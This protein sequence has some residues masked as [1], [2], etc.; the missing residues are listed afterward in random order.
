[1]AG[2]KAEIWFNVA[3]K[4]PVISYG[5]ADIETMRMS[6]KL[7]V[8]RTVQVVATDRSGEIFL[9]VPANTEIVNNHTVIHCPRTNLQAISTRRHFNNLQE[10]LEDTRDGDWLKEGEYLTV[11]NVGAFR[12]MGGSFPDYHMETSGGVKLHDM[13]RRTTLAANTL[14]ARPAGTVGFLGGIAYITDP[15]ATGP[16]SD[17]FDLGV[18]G[19]KNADLPKN[20][21]NAIDKCKA[22]AD[23]PMGTEVEAGKYSARHWAEVSQDAASQI[24]YW[25]GVWVRGVRYHKNDRVFHEGST[26]QANNIH[27]SN[28]FHDDMNIGRWQI[29]A[30][31][32]E[33]GDNGRNVELRK[34]LTHVQWRYIGDENWLNLIPLA[35][36]NGRSFTVDQQG[37]LVDRGLFDDEPVG[38]AYLAT[39]NG[40]LYFRQGDAGGWSDGIPFGKGDA[41]TDGREVQLRVNASHV[42]WQYDGDA[43]W[44]NLV[45]LETIRG[46]QGVQG[47]PGVDGTDGVDGR[48]VELRQTMTHIQWR[49]VGAPTWADLMPLSAIT[50]PQGLPGSDGTDGREIE[51]RNASSYIQ[52]RYVGAVNWN[53]LVPLTAITGPAGDT[54]DMRSTGGMIQWKRTSSGTW[55]NL[56]DTAEAVAG[57][58]NVGNRYEVNGTQVVGAQRNAIAD[59]ASSADNKATVNA[60]LAALRA[61]GLIAT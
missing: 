26:Y 36:I 20:I 38:F 61:H 7:A 57:V 14:A 48:N 23:A 12:I 60:I 16:S 31:G 35:E 37:P 13:Q 30:L 29:F 22:W 50:G 1:M 9:I 6:E 2:N 45:S 10:M 40:E 39:D 8:G 34:S 56:F 19:L 51:F 15:M 43:G 46:P 47:L 5:F 18:D 33:D 54:V 55:L 42:Q 25:R 44:T 17:V 11:T 24:G 41:G 28:E 58:V 49:Y 21:L 3:T 27:V 53:N 59:D 4:N 52:W 32:G